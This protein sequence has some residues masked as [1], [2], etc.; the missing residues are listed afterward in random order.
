VSANSASVKNKAVGANK[1][2][3]AANRVAAAA[4]RV[5]ASKAD[6]KILSESSS[7]GR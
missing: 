6:D 4:K 2:A 3:V 7:G 1:A 5:A